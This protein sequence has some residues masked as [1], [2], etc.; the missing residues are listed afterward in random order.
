MILITN[1]EIKNFKIIIALALRL[2]K[3][4]YNSLRFAKSLLISL[5]RTL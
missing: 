5:R 1:Y 2:Y 3:I 4:V